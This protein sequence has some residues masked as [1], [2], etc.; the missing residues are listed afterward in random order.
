MAARGLAPLLS[1]FRLPR[2][3]HDASGQHT[4]QKSHELATFLWV[5]A[6]AEFSPPAK[7]LFFR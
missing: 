3:P 6:L 7:Y 1:S 4:S 2:Q 5:R